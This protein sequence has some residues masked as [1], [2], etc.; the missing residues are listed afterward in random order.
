MTSDDTTP[1]CERVW[2]HSQAKGTARVIVLALA[3]ACD[4]PQCFPSPLTA[5]D[6]IRYARSSPRAYRRSLATLHN[7]GE[8]AYPDDP[9]SPPVLAIACPPGCDQ[10]AGDNFSHGPWGARRHT[11]VAE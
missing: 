6:L 1:A 9:N 10:G 3:F 7:L 4:A 2:N 8:I 5:R 11:V